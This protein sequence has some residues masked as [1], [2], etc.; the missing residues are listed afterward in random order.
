MNIFGLF[1]FYIGVNQWKIQ[2]EIDIDVY[3]PS[4][5]YSIYHR[6]S[7]IID[8]YCLKII[9]NGFFQRTFSSVDNRVVPVVEPMDT[10]V[11][12][13]NNQEEEAE[14]VNTIPSIGRIVLDLYEKDGKTARIHPVGDDID[15]QPDDVL[16]GFVGLTGRGKSQLL[17]CL[18]GHSVFK[19]GSRPTTYLAT[20]I[21]STFDDNR[22][23]R[24]WIID[25]PV[26]SL[27]I[28]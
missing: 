8:E 12:N 1:W 25:A 10:T 7:S 19:S 2:N 9:R 11:L 5:L 13:E 15:I 21:L 24:Y 20:G 16:V 3:Q 4:Y 28:F 18:T 22:D 17:R 14:Q 6:M 27:E 26:R 23:H